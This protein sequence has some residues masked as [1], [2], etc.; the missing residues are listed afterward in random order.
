MNSKVFV[1]QVQEGTHSKRE[2]VT[3]A[4]EYKERGYLYVTFKDQETRQR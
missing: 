2:S 1:D 4:H 3:N